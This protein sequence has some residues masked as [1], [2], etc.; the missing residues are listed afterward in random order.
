M[1][2]S[3]G[4]ALLCPPPHTHT[5]IPLEHSDRFGALWIGQLEV[6]RLT[7]PEPSNEIHWAVER[8]LT[9]ALSYLITGG[10]RKAHL[11]I[12]NVVN[13]TYTGQI[14]INA[15]VTLYESSPAAGAPEAADAVVGIT[16]NTSSSGLLNEIGKS[17]VTYSFTAPGSEFSKAELH[18]FASG[19]GCEEL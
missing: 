14:F 6:L 4:R 18:V 8:D 11:T 5:H 10:T 1:P 3:L 2:A 9:S 16:G 12:P 15:S 7:T 17:N 19:H 13:P